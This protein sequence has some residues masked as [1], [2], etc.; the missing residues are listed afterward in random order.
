MFEIKKYA[1]NE[2]FCNNK[3]VN[4]WQSVK[5]AIF[6]CVPNFPLYGTILE[7][8]WYMCHKLTLSTVV[9]NSKDHYG[10]LADFTS[11]T[12]LAMC[13]A[14]L[15]FCNNSVH[16]LNTIKNQI[17]DLQWP[18]KCRILPVFCLLTC[19]DAMIIIL[20]WLPWY[21]FSW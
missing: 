14:L 16:L 15:Y 8:V 12:H 7:E 5:F 11:K 4:A 1:L 21:K 3:F 6:F 19:S 9:R 20:S 17:F 10:L 13:L 2:M 18:V